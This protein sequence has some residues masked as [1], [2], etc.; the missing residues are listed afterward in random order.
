MPPIGGA[1]DRPGLPCRAC[2]TSSIAGRLAARCPN[3]AR[4]SSS[5]SSPALR[6]GRSAHRCAGVPARIVHAKASMSYRNA[7]ECPLPP[8]SAGNHV[9][10]RSQSPES[11]TVPERRRHPSHDAAWK[12]FFALSVVVEHLLGGFFREVAALAHQSSRPSPEA[13]REIYRGANTLEADVERAVWTQARCRA[14]SRPW[15]VGPGCRKTWPRR[16]LGTAPGSAPPR[17]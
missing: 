2:T 9:A 11:T 12:Q 10:S 14:Y 7:G 17:T 1:S 8:P 16:C 4:T 13:I 3:G 15:R 6:T 5:A